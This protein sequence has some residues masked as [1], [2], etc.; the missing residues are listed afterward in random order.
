MSNRPK[1]VFSPPCVPSFLLLFQCAEVLDSKVHGN[2]HRILLV[3]L[4]FFLK[5]ANFFPPVF[6]FFSPPVPSQPT[7]QLSFG[8]HLKRVFQTSR[9]ILSHRRTYSLMILPSFSHPP[10]SNPFFDPF[11]ELLDVFFFQISDQWSSPPNRL[12]HHFIMTMCKL[13]FLAVF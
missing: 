7:H 3:F 13:N 9:I 8:S 5:V 12:Q 11:C 6:V 1:A 10:F 2:V 4:G